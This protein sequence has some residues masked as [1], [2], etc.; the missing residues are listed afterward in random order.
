[1]MTPLQ[2]KLGRTALGWTVRQLA[3]TAKVS[4]NTVSR[5]ESGKTEAQPSTVIVM[6]QALE[7]GGVEFTNGDQPGVRLK[8]KGS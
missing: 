1:M 8:R 7:A 6:Q 3:H 4:A 5:F 2:C